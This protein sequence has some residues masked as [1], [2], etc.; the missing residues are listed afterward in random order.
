[1]P[2]KQE[3]LDYNSEIKGVFGFGHV[4]AWYTFCTFISSTHSIFS[5]VCTLGVYLAAG[6]GEGVT[7]YCI[8]WSQN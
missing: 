2:L 7:Y 6:V 4:I 3:G 1:M 8:T 5:T